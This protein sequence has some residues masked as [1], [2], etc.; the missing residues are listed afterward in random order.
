MIVI[1]YNHYFISSVDSAVI[2]LKNEELGS[3]IEEEEDISIRNKLQ[4]GGQQLM[5]LIFGDD[6]DDTEPENR[7]LRESATLNVQIAIPFNFQILTAKTSEENGT[8]LQQE[9]ILRL[10][11]NYKRAKTDFQLTIETILRYLEYNMSF[12]TFFIFCD[13][14]PY[15]FFNDLYEKDNL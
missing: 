3:L 6:S 2:L 15:T 9:V 11:E 4:P 5:D 14:A 10:H 8:L 7:S 1:N 13:S 12:K